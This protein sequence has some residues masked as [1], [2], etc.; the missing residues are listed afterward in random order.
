MNGEYTLSNYRTEEIKDPKHC[1]WTSHDLK[2]SIQFLHGKWRIG[3]IIDNEFGGSISINEFG[4]KSD[5]DLRIAFESGANQI[6][7]GSIAV[8]NAEVFKKWLSQYGGEKIILGADVKGMHIAVNGWTETSDDE[9]IPFIKDYMQDGV[10][11]VICTDIQKD[12]MLAGPAIALYQQLL[13]DCPQLKLIASGGVSEEAE[14]PKLAAI[15]CEGVIIGKA[16]Y[17]NKIS[18]KS[19]EKYI[20]N[21]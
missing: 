20:L 18:L 3:T 21:N 9:L 19:L 6:T 7:G 16:I 13:A 15:G 17:E 11:Y 4:L 2:S 10:Q 8:K 1:Q 12:G 5:D 14:L